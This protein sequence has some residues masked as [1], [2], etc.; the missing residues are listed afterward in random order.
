MCLE[1]IISILLNKIIKYFYGFRDCPEA[2]RLVKS[3]D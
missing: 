1:R 3:K 2:M